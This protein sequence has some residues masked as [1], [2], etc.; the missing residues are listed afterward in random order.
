VIVIVAAA[1]A[2][3]VAVSLMQ[4]HNPTIM[5][6]WL[7]TNVKMSSQQPAWQWQKHK[8]YAN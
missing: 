2:A 5:R 1:A 7:W 8:L 6:S 3:A 4:Q